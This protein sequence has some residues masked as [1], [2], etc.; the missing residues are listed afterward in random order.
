MTLE[1]DKQAWDH[2]TEQ[3]PGPHEH[4][5]WR[6]GNIAAGLSLSFHPAL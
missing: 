5:Q 2:S 3:I 6:L 4:Q 1:G